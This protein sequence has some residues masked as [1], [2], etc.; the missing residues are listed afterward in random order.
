MRKLRAFVLLSFVCLSLTGANLLATSDPSCTPGM[1]FRG[2][3]GQLLDCFENAGADC[4]TC[5]MV[6]V[7]Q[8]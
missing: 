8:G 3:D 6:I 1:A 7:V 5:G 2:R 4:M